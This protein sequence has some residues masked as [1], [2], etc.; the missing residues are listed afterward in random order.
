MMRDRRPI[1][2]LALVAFGAAGAVFGFHLYPRK[3]ADRIK[4]MISWD[5]S[6]SDVTIESGQRRV[7]AVKWAGVTDSALIECEYLGPS[8]F[9]ARFRARTSL[10]RAL[11]RWSPPR[12]PY[13]V[14]G[15]EFVSAD[16]LF[17]RA[18]FRELCDDLDGRF[19]PTPSH[20]AS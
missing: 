6:C 19:S 5:S 3:G 14:A 9:W 7:H 1:A 4:H 13:C 2:V 17:S 8:A 11:R 20:A 16:L 10:V 12:D 15:R 18:Q